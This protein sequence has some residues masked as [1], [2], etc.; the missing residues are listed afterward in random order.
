LSLIV[1]R[2]QKFETFK[3]KVLKKYTLWLKKKEV[4]GERRKLCMR[5]C[6]MRVIWCINNK[7]S[8]VYNSNCTNNCT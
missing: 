5:I 3:K 2:E 7:P 8:S 6:L 4:T 1:R